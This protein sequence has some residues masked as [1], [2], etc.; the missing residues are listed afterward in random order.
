MS[1]LIGGSGIVIQSSVLA[2]AR[3]SSA[4]SGAWPRLAARAVSAA[5]TASKAACE[6]L[7]VFSCG[8]RSGH[9]AA[10][11]RSSATEASASGVWGLL[12]RGW[13]RPHLRSEAAGQAATTVPAPVRST[14]RAA[15][16]S[17][18]SRTAQRKATGAIRPAATL[19][20][21]SC[22][23]PC[24]TASVRRMATGRRHP[25]PRPSARSATCPGRWAAAN[26]SLRPA[27]RTADPGPAG[28]PHHFQEDI[29]GRET[30]NLPDDR[31][32]S[33]MRRWPAPS[34]PA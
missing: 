28:R 12:R 24:T 33:P 16:S 32:S 23:L 19:T 21:A 29:A 10:A 20:G 11:R 25:V 17:L 15:A 7:I 2:V 34:I 3:S 27:G 4:G 26:E 30:D 22:R 13:R 14:G 1:R 31:A 8:P 18:A 9:G 5:M 6:R